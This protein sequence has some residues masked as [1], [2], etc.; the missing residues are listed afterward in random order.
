MKT[1]KIPQHLTVSER[2][3]V[4]ND[5]K[6]QRALH[7]LYLRGNKLTQMRQRHWK[8]DGEMWRSTVHREREWKNRDFFFPEENSQA[9]YHSEHWDGCK[10]QPLSQQ[11]PFVS[12]GERQKEVDTTVSS[13]E[14][15]WWNK[16]VDKCSPPY[17]WIQNLKTRLFSHYIKYNFLLTGGEDKQH[18]QAVSIHPLAK[19]KLSVQNKLNILVT[20]NIAQLKPKT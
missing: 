18:T 1:I 5:S 6:S 8:I 20:H 14:N 15:S 9:N 12:R 3:K 2:S 13:E 10:Q 7:L 11:W 19:Q 17:Y 4:Q 16:V